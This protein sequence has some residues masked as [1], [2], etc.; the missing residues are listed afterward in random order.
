[1]QKFYLSSDGVRNKPLNNRGPPLRSVT[2]RCQPSDTHD[3]ALIVLE[4]EEDVRVDGGVSGEARHSV[5]LSINDNFFSNF[6]SLSELCNRGGGKRR[7][8]LFCLFN[9]P[10]VFCTIL[11]YFE[12]GAV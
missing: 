4:A 8:V 2:G 1:M 10:S 6:D 12:Q 3:T 9:G 11:I 7:S 5:P